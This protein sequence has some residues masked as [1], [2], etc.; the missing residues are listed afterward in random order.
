MEVEKISRVKSFSLHEVSRA[1]FCD[2]ATASLRRNS[3]KFVSNLAMGSV[4]V[5]ALASSLLIGESVVAKY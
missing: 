5:S 1:D 4:L 2:A 3:D